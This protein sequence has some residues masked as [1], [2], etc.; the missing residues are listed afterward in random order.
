M[1]RMTLQVKLVLLALA[2]DREQERYGLEIIDATGLPPGTIYP[3]LARLERA[4]WLDSE[5]ETVDEH[6]AGRPR[7]RYY[8]LTA[9]GA[10]VATTIAAQSR[11][12]RTASAFVRPVPR[13]AY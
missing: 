6:L 1:P 4:G 12:A 3:I 8:R 7:R 2:E 10:A 9:D 5:W 11:G 13:G